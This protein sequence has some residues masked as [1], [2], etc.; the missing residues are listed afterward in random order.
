MKKKEKDTLRKSERKR[1]GERK[2]IT[3][4]GVGTE[5]KGIIKREREREES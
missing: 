2:M 1:K 4:E 5:I 3:N